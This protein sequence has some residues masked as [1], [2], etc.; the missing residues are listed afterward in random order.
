MESHSK[1]CPPVWFPTDLIWLRPSDADAEGGGVWAGHWEHQWRWPGQGPLA[2]ESLLRSTCMY[3][4]MHMWSFLHPKIYIDILYTC[5][6]VGHEGGWVWGSRME[7]GWLVLRVGRYWRGDGS[8]PKSDLTL[9]KV[10]PGLLLVLHVVSFPDQTLPQYPV[11][12]QGSY[13]GRV[14]SRV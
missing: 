10:K 7:D 2:Q 14:R 1:A 3:C 9:S 4:Q 5:I 11:V 8:K 12:V 13:W 6:H